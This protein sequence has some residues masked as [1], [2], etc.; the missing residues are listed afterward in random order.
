VFLILALPFLIDGIKAVL[1][2]SE[3]NVYSEDL[4]EKLLPE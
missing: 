2:V 1:N 4:T 3:K